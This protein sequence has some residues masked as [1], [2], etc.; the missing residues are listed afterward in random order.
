MVLTIGIGLVN[1]EN[2]KANKI[3][4]ISVIDYW[5]QRLG[6]VAASL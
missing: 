3:A 4:M 1:F 6:K 2:V 5:R